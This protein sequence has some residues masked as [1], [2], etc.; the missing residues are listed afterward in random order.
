MHYFILI[1]SRVLVNSV[2]EEDEIHSFVIY[3]RVVCE[4]TFGKQTDLTTDMP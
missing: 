2:S 3:H 4:Q 1:I